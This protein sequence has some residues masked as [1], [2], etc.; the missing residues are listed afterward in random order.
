[1]TSTYIASHLTLMFVSVAVISTSMSVSPLYIAYAATT[2]EYHPALNGVKPGADF[3]PH[4][5][6]AKAR[7]LNYQLGLRG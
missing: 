3:H 5:Q 2:L 7:K 6:V 1:M 4:F